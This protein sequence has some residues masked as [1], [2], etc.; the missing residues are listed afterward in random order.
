MARFT[1]K[2]DP[3][4]RLRRREE[5][6]RQR[7]LAVLLRRQHDIENQIRDIQRR[8][9]E[10]K[11]ELGSRLAGRVDAP[12]IRAHAQMTIDLD[13]RARQFAVGL[14]EVYR[15]IDR[16]RG[17][18]IEARRRRRA[19]ELLRERRRDEWLRSYRRR[20]A[21]E[22]DDLVMSRYARVRTEV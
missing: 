4:L 10:G 9:E 15:Q 16:A 21:N 5:E 18:L 13:R 11:R 3:L 17:E 22:I 20:E 7:D 12:A 6:E 14:A 2:L 8:I 19:L 1:F